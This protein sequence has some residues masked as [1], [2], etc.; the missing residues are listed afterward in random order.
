MPVDVDRLTVELIDDGRLRRQDLGAD[1][2]AV[3]SQGRGQDAGVSGA[4]YVLDTPASSNL[5]PPGVYTL[6]V[7]MREDGFRF[8]KIVLTIKS[9]RQYCMWSTG[10]QRSIYLKIVI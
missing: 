9:G 5:A 1:P 2:V 6:N 10:Q 8:D 4:A 3:L 7:W